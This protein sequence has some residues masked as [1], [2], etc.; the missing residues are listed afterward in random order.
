MKVTRELIALLKGEGYVVATAESCTGGLVA[1][2]ITAVPGSSEVFDRG[3]VTYSNAAKQDM[4]GVSKNLLAKH[5]AVSAEVAMAMARGAIRNSKANAAIAITGI[6]GPGGAT[7]TK[8]VGLVFVA[9][10]VKNQKPFHIKLNIGNIGRQAV[11]KIAVEAAIGILE[12]F[13]LR[14]R[15]MPK[16]YKRA[17]Y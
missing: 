11:R 3:F 2:A 4:L 1:A 8:P 17:K 14:D 16:R 15:Q 9:G 7:E 13:V 12:G 6:A 10:A 5:G